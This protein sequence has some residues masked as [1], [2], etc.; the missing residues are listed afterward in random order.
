MVGTRR[1]YWSTGC[2]VKSHA[3]KKFKMECNA[4]WFLASKSQPMT[5]TPT[6]FMMPFLDASKITEDTR[7]VLMNTLDCKTTEEWEEFIEGD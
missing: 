5:G 7:E 3:S 1:F 4:G 6:A 2:K